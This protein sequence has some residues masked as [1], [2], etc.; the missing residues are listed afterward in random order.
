MSIR[1]I[2]LCINEQRFERSGVLRGMVSNGIIRLDESIE[3]LPDQEIVIRQEDGSV[4]V[5]NGLQ[6]NGQ[7]NGK[8]F[9]SPFP[10]QA[11]GIISWLFQ[12]DIR[13]DYIGEPII[14]R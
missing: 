5:I 9:H 11:F 6:V 12:T 2:S 13:G 7:I 8:E 10:C 3:A 4:L 1:A 14:G